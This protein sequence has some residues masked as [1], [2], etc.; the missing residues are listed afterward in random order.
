[1]ESEPEGAS[2]WGRSLYLVDK[3]KTNRHEETEAE[4][5]VPGGGL[6]GVG[7]LCVGGV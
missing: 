1:M 4:A 6:I 2:R 3:N 5:I 7:W